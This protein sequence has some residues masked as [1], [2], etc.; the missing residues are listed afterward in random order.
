MGDARPKG[1]LLKELFDLLS[2]ETSIVEFYFQLVRTADKKKIEQNLF[3]LLKKFEGNE[4][5]YINDFLLLYRLLGQ[6]RDI[7]C[8]K[9]EQD[10]SFLQ[11]YIWHMF[12]PELAFFAFYQ[13]IYPHSI[14][15]KSYGS[16]K[17]VKTF[18]HFIKK[19][20]NNENHPLILYAMDIM[21]QQIYIDYSVVN[22]QQNINQQITLAGKWAPRQRSKHHW[23]FKKMAYQYYSYFF[24]KTK[25]ITA[26]KNASKMYFR[27]ILSK[28]NY[29]LKTPQI[30]MASREWSK[31]DFE[32]TT[33][34]TLLYFRKSFLK[35]DKSIDRKI[36]GTNFKAFIKKK[37]TIS[38]KMCQPYELVK[39]AFLA[40][41]K[42][43]IIF[44]NKQWKDTDILNLGNGIPII[45]VGVL[46]MKNNKIPLYNAIGLG[47][48]ISE[49]THQPFKNC[50]MIYGGFSQWI[51]F[52]NDITF[53]EKV[54]YIMNKIILSDTNIFVPINMLLHSFIENHLPF[55]DVSKMTIYI[56]SGN[57][58][59]DI[60][61]NIQKMFFDAGILS[62]G[63]PY[64][65]P[66]FI[67]WN[68]YNTKF[69][70]ADIQSKN[71]TFVSGY[72]KNILK[73][74]K[75]TNN[76][77][78]KTTP[79]SKISTILFYKRYDTLAIFALKFISKII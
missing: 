54:Q 63:I 22:S 49:N 38:S 9:G 7:I 16:W 71:V 61:T 75:I 20:T 65:L 21:L 35:Q 64:Y 17:D 48:K 3:N 24:I 53:V 29:F 45:D 28:L 46:S 60:Y 26:A 73:N 6:T 67:F 30:F 69:L 4:I 36:C 25:N 10:L 33:S 39:A 41:D 2:M 1:N 78:K 12:Y 62:I 77:T 42:D 76:P 47:I 74:I 34:R 43:E 18:C 52:K 50:L 51:S 59:Y 56:L 5:N 68:L 66:H 58:N 44:I 11:I 19:K 79:I 8:G 72:T 40:N 37:T 57:Y 27:K 15:E 55:N 23:L 70:P 32:K 14:T 13:F 31:I